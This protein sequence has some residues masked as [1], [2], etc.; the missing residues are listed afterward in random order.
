MNSEKSNN[1]F[2]NFLVKKIALYTS[3]SYINFR[4]R[5]V[6]WFFI[7]RKYKS[8]EYQYNENIKLKL[9]TDRLLSKLIYCRQFE[10]DEF[11][12]M[13]EYIKK[14]F[15][16]FD[17]GANIGLHSL[18]LANVIGSKGICY[19]FEPTKTTFESL[20]EN[21]SLNGLSNIIP[22]NL[23]LSDKE[24]ILQIY[25]STNGYDA[26]N[27]LGGFQKIG[28][29]KYDLEN[30]M[31]VPLDIFLEKNP[32]IRKPDFMKIDTE[33]W[34]L[35]VL[36]GCSNLLK[37]SNPVIMMEYSQRNLNLT[38][39]KQSELYDYLNSLGYKLFKYDYKNNKFSL[40]NRNDE[41]DYINVI[42][43]KELI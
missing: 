18:Y 9:Y 38:N 42:A 22:Y 40:I 36:K 14:D 19:S 25:K 33:G 31:C 21:I 2:L 27:S 20:N 43:S 1:N 3:K 29:N 28:S 39:T 24:E 5:S 13:S 8:I 37:K 15:I 17:I 12:F 7:K 10:K 4:I 11:R 34:E 23:A 26:W 41:Y 32:E 16:V 35:H 30:V 6:R